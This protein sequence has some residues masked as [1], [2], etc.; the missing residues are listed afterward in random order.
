L[1]NGHTQGTNFATDGSTGSYN[2]TGGVAF[3]NGDEVQVNLSYD[4]TTLT[5]DLTDLAN[6]D[7]YSASYATDLSSVLGSG[8][9]YVGFSGGTGGLASTQTISNFSFE[10][11]TSDQIQLSGEMTNSEDGVQSVQ[12]A[13]GTVWTGQQLAF[14]ANTGTTGSDTITGTP[15]ND[16]LNG[17]GGNDYIAGDGG[18]D[19]YIF[20]QG[21]GELTVNN[22]SATGTSAAGQLD[23]GAGI[24]E[25]NLWFVQ[26]GNNLAIDVLGSQD[27]VVVQNWFDSSTPSA[28]LSEIEGSDGLEIDS[29]VSQLVQAMA[30]Y[31]SNNPGFN[32][33]T[34][35]QMPSDT[36]LQSA[37]ASAWHA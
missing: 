14:A 28:A 26:S 21:Y 13:D 3:W 31:S 2:S 30:T 23:F 25:N 9:A 1:Y 37:I 22:A 27:Q 4:G 29:Q 32:P 8:T 10:P 18:N 11:G 34:A 20:N 12:F 19:T 36:A 6:G 17:R 16:I 24:N 35:T 15:G 5:E 7:T 33:A